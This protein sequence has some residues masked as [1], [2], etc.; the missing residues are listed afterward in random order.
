[1]KERPQGPARGIEDQGEGEYG[2]G[3]GPAQLAGQLLHAGGGAEHRNQ[4]H[5]GNSGDILEHRHGQA[6]PAMRRGILALLRQLAADDG[7]RRLREDGADDEGEHRRLASQPEQH[8][9]QGG[10]QQDLRGAQAKDLV[11]HRVQLRQRIGQPDGK[12]QED[13][14]ELGQ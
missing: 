1:M 4:D 5:E 10:G 6:K 8:G 9:D 2:L 11:A 3:C 14:A 12:E 7:G 13:H